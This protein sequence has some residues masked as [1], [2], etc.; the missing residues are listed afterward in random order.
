MKCPNPNSK[1][2]QDLEKNKNVTQDHKNQIYVQLE[3]DQFKNWFGYTVKDKNGKDGYDSFNYPRLIDNLYIKNIKGDKIKLFDLINTES[4]EKATDLKNR[5]NILDGDI[6]FLKKQAVGM[7]KRLSL[8]NGSDYAETMQREVIDEVNKLAENEYEQA[9]AIYTKYIIK[10]IGQFQNRLFEYENYNPIGKSVEALKERDE[11]YFIALLQ[12]NEFLQTFEE[13]KKLPATEGKNKRTSI[14]NQLRHAE[15]TVSDL[16]NTVKKETERLWSEKLKSFSTNPQIVEGAL[17][18]LSAQ[19]D[20][21]GAQ[22]W[23]DSLADSHHPVLASLGKMYNEY[24]DLSE[25][26]VKKEIREWKKFC[27]DNGLTTEKDFK[28]FTEGGKFL[29]EFNYE[30]FYK[31][32]NEMKAEMREL[33]EAGKKFKEDGKSVT[34]EFSKARDKYYDW[35]NANTTTIDSKTNFYTPNKKWVNEAYAKLSKE[36][37]KQLDYIKGFLE[38]QIEHTNKEQTVKGVKIVKNDTLIAKGYLPAIPNYELPQSDKEEQLGKIITESNDIVRFIPFKYMKLLNQKELPS[39]TEGMTDEQKEAVNKEREKIIAENKLSHANSINYNLYEVMG[40]FIKAANT[41]KFKTELQPMVQASVAAFK[42]L[43]IKGK[44]AKGDTYTD[45]IASKALGETVDYEK[46]A[47][48]SNAHAHLK[49]WVEG[50]F[51]EEFNYDE[52]KLTIAAEKIQTVSSILGIGFRPLAAINNK[53]VGNL[54]LLL[55]AAGAQYF[56]GKD[57]IKARKQY[58]DVITNVLAE[59]G[60][61]S[62]G[63]D[64]KAKTL[65]TALIRGFN[66][67]QTQDELAV[68]P[69]SLKDKVQHEIRMLYD[70]AYFMQ[71]IGEHQIQ[72]TVLLAMLHSHRVVKGKIMSYANYAKQFDISAAVKKMTEEGKSSEEIKLY[73][74]NNKKDAKVLKKEFEEYGKLIDEYELKNGEAVLK[75]GSVIT[76]KQLSNFKNKVIG[77]NQKLHGIYNKDDAA[78]L[79]RYALARLGMQFR[80]WIRPAWNRRFGRRFGKTDYNERLEEY[81]EGMYISTFK[82][83]SQPFITNYKQYKKEQQGIAMSAFKAFFAG[84]KDTMF[85]AKINWHSMNDMEKANVRRTALEVVLTISAVILTNALMGDDDDKEDKNWLQVWSIYEAD[86]LY[87]ELSTFMPQGVLREGNRLFDNPIA[88]FR[89]FDAVSKLTWNTVMYPIREDDDEREFKSGIY[90]GRDKVSVYFLNIIPIANEIQKMYYLEDAN[91]RYIK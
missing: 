85:N 34:K 8:Y 21:G 53:I 32:M 14:V 61:D 81:S 45:K 24:K 86:R 87:G 88:A 28:K 39:I 51:Y 17:D 90:H 71:H 91:R 65:T 55:E 26:K 46:S 35:K 33:E 80:K 48:N 75:E 30:E 19:E 27:E 82:Y 22:R 59:H 66:I 43:K 36:E 25:I 62:K 77:V 31:E 15:A 54:Q 57:L 11:K 47:E 74:D 7:Q 4:F 64:K 83:I 70:M 68:T 9:L 69:N 10:T 72:N 38:K 67:L 58:F 12:M 89:T 49:D 3:S 2:V 50:V 13:I 60:K 84:F 79:Q 20:E 1:F 78:M 52:G 37:I 16:E 6:A 56:D 63:N 76:D 40:H 5:I 29:E 41:N 42:H 44:S 18:F 73:I 23:L